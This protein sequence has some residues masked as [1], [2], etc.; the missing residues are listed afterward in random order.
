MRPGDITDEMIPTAD[1]EKVVEQYTGWVKRIANR[2]AALLERTGSID[3][4]DLCQ[5]GYLALLKAKESY[6]PSGGASFMTYS[7]FGIRSAIRRE[8]G[9]SSDG[10]L[11]PILKSLDEPLDDE[12][13]ATLADM[14]EDPNIMPFDESMIEAETKEETVAEVHAAV[15]RL[16]NQKQRDTIKRIWFDGEARNGIAADIGLSPQRVSAIEKRGFR[17]LRQDKQLVKIAK[18]IV[19]FIHVGSSRFNTTWTSATEWA[20][21]W[22]DEHLAILTTTDGVS[23]EA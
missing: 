5:V 14:I 21:L 22:R 16:K 8:L 23:V 1:P 12:A 7:A 11:P 19:P 9:F 10:Q 3:Y 6:S 4:E 2:Y 13:D 18:D 17:E 15:D 20:V